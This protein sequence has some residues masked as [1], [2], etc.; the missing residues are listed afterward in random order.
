MQLIDNYSL[1]LLFGNNTQQTHKGF[2]ETDK[3]GIGKI[4][5][6]GK[7]VEGKLRHKVETNSANGSEVKDSKKKSFEG[8]VIKSKEKE[9]KKKLADEVLI[10]VNIAS[11]QILDEIEHELSFEFENKEYLVAELGSEI[12]YEKDI[13]DLELSIAPL[14]ALVT[15]KTES[16][17]EAITKSENFKI[18][19]LKEIQSN[20]EE[21]IEN[22]TL[23]IA[24]LDLSTE[25]GVNKILELSNNLE[26]L[27][28][29]N[30]LIKERIIEFS[31]KV[32]PS[33]NS[34]TQMNNNTEE[35][36]LNYEA[37]T[38][39][40]SRLEK[41]ISNYRELKANNELKESAENQSELSDL[42]RDT[43][44][45][46]EEM[47][48]QE[49]TV[50]EIPIEESA[51]KEI[52]YKQLQELNITNKAL[53]SRD[54]IEILERNTNR[55]ENLD[56]SQEAK[57]SLNESASLLSAGSISFNMSGS[58]QHSNSGGQTQQTV[59][60]SIQQGNATSSKVMNTRAQVIKQSVPMEK[61]ANFVT[62]K[63]IQ[64]PQGVKQDIKLLLNPE[65]L[66]EVELSIS[67]QGNKIDI[68]LVFA[69]ERSMNQV[70]HKM[71][72][73]SILL[74]SRGFEAKIEIGHTNADNTNNTSD[75]HNANSGNQSFNQA[76]EEQKNK[77]LDRPSWLDEAISTEG[78]SFDEQL[79]GIIN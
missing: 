34:P 67:R 65:N 63:A 51:V 60:Q 27:S 4:S 78:L 33:Q 24:K 50:K 40:D 71:N 31:A 43:N 21:K 38:L 37:K 45:S 59:I 30:D 35:S 5:S 57:A 16:P 70:E 58:Q 20:L 22:L 44:I 17:S 11:I 41:F 1:D 77:Y 15:A 23:K 29:I 53:H 12:E 54:R 8:T 18:P 52:Q 68:K 2:V 61:L 10:E 6:E 79:Q 64:T 26:E 72:E 39:I 25:V 48:I 47:P 42:R 13:S 28:K 19:T 32:F 3:S 49:S 76:K 36:L 74:K 69:N 66:G 7:E 9:T 56:L 55:E 73:L 46:R 14:T 75:Q 62:E